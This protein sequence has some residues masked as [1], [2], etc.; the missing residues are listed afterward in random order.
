MENEIV[1]EYLDGRISNLSNFNSSLEFY[2]RRG[3]M[4]AN[5]ILEGIFNKSDLN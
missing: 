5:Y 2:H 4:Q 3:F 1:L